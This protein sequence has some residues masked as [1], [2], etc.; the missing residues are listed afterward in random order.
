[1]RHLAGKSIFLF[2]HKNKI[3]PFTYT[4]PFCPLCKLPN[5]D[6]TRVFKC[7]DMDE[8]FKGELR[9]EAPDWVTS[10]QVM[11]MRCIEL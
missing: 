10:D 4:S 5:H 9:I 1:M 8:V 6:T 2:S 7:A 11:Q 3:D